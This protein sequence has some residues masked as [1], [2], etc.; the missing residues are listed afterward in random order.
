M[1]SKINALCVYN[2]SASEK[3]KECFS[4]TLVGGALWVTLQIHFR[5]HLE[6]QQQKKK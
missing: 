6:Q 4:W 5:G 1:K 2:H 3:K